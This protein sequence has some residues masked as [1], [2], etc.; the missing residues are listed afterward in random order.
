MAVGGG[1]A[2]Q[3][4]YAGYSEWRHEHFRVK[5][6]APAAVDFRVYYT[7][8]SSIVGCQSLLCVCVKCVA[9]VVVVVAIYYEIWIHLNEEYVHSGCSVNRVLLGALR[10]V[11][12]Y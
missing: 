8:Y 7:Y 1:E 5:L 11:P 12:L 6:L 4:D 9:A 2:F 3:C 10:D